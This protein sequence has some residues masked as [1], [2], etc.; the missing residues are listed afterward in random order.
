MISED[1]VYRNIC[2]NIRKLRTE[3]PVT[4]KKITQ[5]ELS[6]QIGVTRATLTNIEIG[7]QRPPI[8][9]IYRICEYFSVE[10]DEILP[11]LDSLAETHYPVEINIGGESKAVPPMVHN[12]ILR[13]RTNE[14]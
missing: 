10:L 14:D 13:A 9:V 8:Y 6:E 2:A 4:R 3:H 12:L 5:T 7:N 11:S 1:I